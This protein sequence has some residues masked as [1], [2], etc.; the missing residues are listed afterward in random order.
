M[1]EINYYSA[2]SNIPYCS[3]YTVYVHLQT[4]HW[5]DVLFFEYC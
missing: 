5:I 1:I 3:Y 2:T 4:W